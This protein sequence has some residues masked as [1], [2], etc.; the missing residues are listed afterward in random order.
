M[1]DLTKVLE[2]YGARGVLL[3]LVGV[4]ALWALAHWSAAPGAPVSILWGLVEYT[5]PHPPASSQAT[6]TTALADP[7]PTVGLPSALSPST[8]LPR[9]N[10]RLSGRLP[11]PES[12]DAI[13]PGARLS[14]VTSL[15][16]GGQLQLGN[17][18]A[19]IDSGPFDHLH[20]ITTLGSLRDSDPTVGVIHF[21]FRDEQARSDTRAVLLRELTAYPHRS[22]NLGAQIVWPDVNG[23]EAVLGDTSYYIRNSG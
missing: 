4:S 9:H 17:Y 3:T 8:S 1:I 21:T 10:F 18:S 14:E 13:A 15:Y 11:S 19:P 22:E 5:K 2:K 16:P 23:L 7:S 20:V 6:E 12:L